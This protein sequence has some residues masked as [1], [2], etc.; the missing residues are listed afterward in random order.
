GDSLRRLQRD[1]NLAA[2]RSKRGEAS[3]ALRRIVLDALAARSRE[4]FRRHIA[5][6]PVAQEDSAGTHQGAT[7]YYRHYSVRGKR[8]FTRF[9]AFST[10]CNGSAEIALLI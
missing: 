6:L 9:V 4:E 5:R 3:V 8:K 10:H 2:A 7:G 1:L